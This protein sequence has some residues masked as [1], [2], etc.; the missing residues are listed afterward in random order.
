MAIGYVTRLGDKTSCGGQ[1]LQGNPDF[2]IDGMPQARQGD[3]VSCGVTGK[4]YQIVG[5]IQD[6]FTEGGL[7]A[8]SL[9]SI[10]SCPCQAT[11]LPGSY[12]FAY[13]SDSGSPTSRW[14]EPAISTREGE[15]ANASQHSLAPETASRS[16]T[17]RTAGAGNPSQDSGEATEPGFYI[18]P[19]SMSR[20]ALEAALFDNP[21]LEALSKFRVLNPS[22]GTVKGGSMII[23]S[24]PRNHSCTREEALLQQ[25]AAIVN[26][27]LEP[28]TEEEA[29]FMAR[30]HEEIST[31]LAHTAA[32][33]G[34]G[35]A[36]FSRNLNN[37]KNSMEAMQ[38]LHI[39]SFDR[40]GN[41]KSSQF[42]AE[43]ARLFADLN[44]NLSPLTR[45]AIGFPDHPKLKTALGLSTRSL[46]HHWK[47]AGTSGPIPGYATHI[48]RVSRTAKILKLGGWVGTTVGGGASYVKV[49]QVCSEGNSEACRKV[50]FTE[51]GSFFG[52]LAG[53]LGGGAFAGSVGAGPLCVAIGMGTATVG[54]IICGIVVVGAGSY[55][56]GQFGS[57]SGG[58]IGEI[59]YEETR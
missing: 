30:H 54:G 58:A 43:R 19:Y 40:D 57:W 41:L 22:Q 11:L 59:I 51:T 33:V 13:E 4:T 38:K 14:R 46:V 36:M 3:S 39:D 18:V 6:I 10:S 1:V 49:Q 27:A 42:R 47:K 31:F 23:L 5:G 15:A 24:D 55:A 48:E 34:V 2:L 53:G 28:L 20:S 25:A 29:D 37:V 8:G 9:D 44:T 7:A 32:A 21:S 45:K 50:K 16:S 56:G 52:S 26:K 35:E 12:G 17:P